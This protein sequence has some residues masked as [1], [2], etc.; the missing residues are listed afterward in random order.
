MPSLLSIVEI[1]G[2]PDFNGL[3]QQSGYQTVQA[4]SVRKAIAQM[5]KQAADIIVAEFN[6]QSDFRDRTSNLETLLATIQA[7]YPD[8]RIIVMFENE[9]KHA[10]DRLQLNYPVDIALPFPVSPDMMELALSQLQS[11]E[12][13]A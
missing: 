9:Y 7:R 3:Y 1:G 6:F 2:Y 10:F 8:T 13:K 4:K 11:S 12:S 5:K